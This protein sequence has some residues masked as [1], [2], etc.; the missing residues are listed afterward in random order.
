M[1]SYY[2]TFGKMSKIGNKP[3]SVPASV[4]LTVN[5][6]L[7][8][9]KGSKGELNFEIPSGISISQNEGTLTVTRASDKKDLKSVH[10]LFRSLVANAVTGV[11]TL[12]EKKLAIVGT[13]YNVKLQGEDLIL[14]L[15]FAHLI[16]FKKV[17]GIQ[18][19]VEGN[20]KIVVSGIDKQIVGQ[21]AHQI[22][23]LKKPDAYKGKGI[24]YEGEVVRLKPGKKA[25]A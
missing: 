10:G 9:V 2:L 19:K 12:W 13:G 21:V 5:D 25:K 22:K 24:R 17:D 20:N 1:A 7:V 15:G 14:K 16:T 8:T 3:V 18:Y 23:I 6:K 4:Q 11:E